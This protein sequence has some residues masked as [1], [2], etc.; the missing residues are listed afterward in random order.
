MALK[1]IIVPSADGS[2][3][4]SSL[5][6]CE[7]T[8]LY[9]TLAEFLWR[10]KWEDGASRSTGTITLMVDSGMY[11]AAVNDRDSE[12][13]AFVSGRNLTG[14]LEAIERG[15]TEGS[16]EWRTKRAFRPG[17]KRPGS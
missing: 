4:S 9:P 12:L 15:L 14:L 1:R 8:T 13:S 11:K 2:A 10:A 17:G 5:G 16:L 6:E 3:C 7:L